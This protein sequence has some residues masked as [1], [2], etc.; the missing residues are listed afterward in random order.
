MSPIKFNSQGKSAH[1]LVA[2]V[3]RT[4]AEV[5][6]QHVEKKRR[7]RAIRQR[8]IPT[9]EMLEPHVLL[10]TVTWTNSS[11]GNW[12]VGTNWS[13]GS[14]P[15]SG[16]TAV[17]TGLSSGAQVTYSSGSSTV[18]AIQASSPLDITGGTLAVSGSTEI[19][20]TTVTVD[21]G[22]LEYGSS[23]TNSESGSAGVD[24]ASGNLTLDASITLSNLDFSGGT[25]N[26]T[27]SLSLDG[28]DTWSGGT[29]D[30]PVTVG[31]GATLDVTGGQLGDST[32]SGITLENENEVDIE[33]GSLVLNNSATIDNVLSGE[34]DLAAGANLDA[35]DSTAVSI[36]NDGYI[37]QDGGASPSAIEMPLNNESAGQVDVGG[38]ILQLD[39]GGSNTNIH[40]P[41]FADFA[42]NLEFNGGTFTFYG[43]ATLYATSD[44]QIDL[45][46]GTLSTNAT[47]TAY[48]FNMTGGTVDGTGSLA[49]VG[50]G[51]WDHGVL[52]VPLTVNSGATFDI[53]NG[54]L[55]DSSTSGVTLSNS[56]TVD[57]TGS[58]A[59]FNS[60]AI[61]NASGGV[62]VLDTG[63]SVNAG[64]SSALAFNNAGSLEE[65]GAASAA[66]DLPLV[67]ESTGTVVADG[68]TLQLIDGGS[69]ANTGTAFS[70]EDDGLLWFDVGTY[71]FSG[72]AT[73]TADS[74]SEI[75][76]D[77]VTVTADG[78]L[79]L[80]N[81]SATDVTVSGTGSLSF[82]GSDTWS[83]GSISVPPTVA[84]SGTVTF[85]SATLTLTGLTNQGTIDL[86]S[87]DT[88]SLAGDWTNAS[89]TISVPTGATL[90]LGGDFAT[91]DVGT[92]SN[93]GGE[94]QLTG[95]LDNTSATLNLTTST[96]GASLVME[97]GGSITGGTVD[98][99]SGSDLSVDASQTGTLDG[100]TV[101][102]TGN[103]DASQSGA[104]LT[105]SNGL[106]FSGT[107]T[108]GA[109]ATLELA[110]TETL[111]GGGTINAEQIGSIPYG[112]ENS[113]NIQIDDGATATLDTDMTVSGGS[114]F[115]PQNALSNFINEGQFIAGTG[116]DGEPQEFLWN[117]GGGTF[118]N[119]G[120]LDASGLGGFQT[121]S[122]PL[123]GAGYAISPTEVVFGWS[124]F[125]GS[126][127]DTFTISDSTNGVDFNTIST[128]RPSGNYLVAEGLMPNTSYSFR[129]QETSPGGASL[130]YTS[131]PIDTNISDPSPYA[132]LYIGTPPLGISDDKYGAYQFNN[133]LDGSG[134]P[135]SISSYK[136]GLLDAGSAQGAFLQSLDGYLS[137]NVQYDLLAL[138]YAYST[139]G[140]LS[141]GVHVVSPLCAP[142]IA[143]YDP[144]PVQATTGATSPSNNQCAPCD[145]D[146]ILVS[147]GATVITDTD[148]SSSGFTGAWS[149]TR[150]WT[151]QDTF[152]PDTTF[153]N[154]WMNQTQTYIQA[155]GNGSGNP[156]ILVVQN[157]YNQTLFGYN[158][159]T[160]TYAPVSY[161]NDAL[162]YDSSSDTYTWLNVATGGE[163]IYYGFS[164]GT[165]ANLQGKLKLYQD[166]YGNQ[167]SLTY[168][169]AG[170][171]TTV[172]QSDAAGDESIF[173]YDYLT[174]GVNAGKVSLIEEFVQRAGD[175]S[176]T[177]VEQ[178]AYAYYE[179]TYS[180]D[181]AFGNLGDLKT[182]TIEDPD[183][184]V[185]GEDYYRY[186]TPG[187]I[188]DGAEGFV[189]GLQYTFSTDSFTKLAAAFA[190][191][192][193]ATNAEIAP[194]A[195]EFY[196]YN[197]SRQVI[198]E[199]VGSM[200]ASD[201]LGQGTYH[202][203]Y[204]EN[205]SLSS[206]TED[207]NT[208][209]TRT[210]E[211]LPD[212]NQNIFYTSIDGD[213]ILEIENVSSD[214]GN[215]ANVGG[216]WI[217]GDQYDIFGRPLTSISTSAIN[218]GASILDGATTVSG[219]EA[220]LEPYADLG[221][222][223][224]L[225]YTSQGLITGTTY[226]SDTTATSTT[227]GDAA[228]FVETDFVQQGSSGS[229]INQHSY[230]YFA[231]ANA[232]GYTIYPVASHTQYESAASGGSNPQSTGYGYTWQS[233]SGSVT[234][235]VEDE[236]ITNPT[237]ST[238]D[239]GSG[240]ATSEQEVFNTFGQVVWT[241]DGNGYI[242]YA[243]YDNATGS[244]TQSVQ[245]VN[246]SD[247][248]DLRNYAGTTFTSGYNSLGVPQLP[249][250]WST[251]TGGGSTG[252]TPGG[253][254]LVTT[255]YVDNLG[256][257]IEQVSPAGNITLYAYDDID[258]A[259]FTLPGVVLNTEDDTL[260][261]TG[262]TTMT[263][264]DIPYSYTQGDSTLYGMYDET[265]TFSANTSISYSGGGTGEAVIPSM[266]GFIQGDDASS[267]PKNVLNLI[268]DGSSDSPQFTIQSLTRSLH[269]SSGRT[270]GQ[271]VETD[272]YSQI[273]NA[274]YLATDVWDPYSVSGTSYY[275]T[276]YGFD[277]DGR[278]YQTINANGTIDD[279]VFD[280]MD[281]PVSLWVGT[282]DAVSGASGTPSYF[283]GSN[284][285]SGNNMTDVESF[286]YD[287]GGIGDDDLTEEV[288]YPDG[289]TAGTQ[290]ASVLSYDFEDRLIAKESGLTLNDSGAAVTSGNDAYPQITVDTLDN[291][292][293]IEA[294]LTFNG[295]ATS[296]GDAIT[297]AG[298]TPPVETLTGLVGY[299]TNAYDS[300]KQNYQSQTFSVDPST[301]TISDTALT[302]Q[303]FYD[304]D[305]NVIETVAPNGQDTKNVFDG[306][307]RLTGTF[308]TDGGAVNNS[309]SP[310][311]TYAAASSVF[312]DVVIQQTAYGYNGDGDTIETVTAQRSSADPD[313]AEGA[314]FSDTSNSDGSLNV[315]AA[316]GDDS[317][318]GSMIDFDASYFD[319]ADRDIADVNVG[320]NGSSAWTRPT[321][322]PSD[323]ST[324]LVTGY[325]YDA[326][327]NQNTTTDPNGIETKSDFDALGRMTTNIA[328]YTDG[329]PTSSTNQTTAY[330]YDGLNDITSMTAVMPSGTPDQTTSYIYGV[331]TTGGSKIDSNDLLGL[332]DYPNP[333]TG[334]ASSSYQQ[335]FEYDAIGEEIS[336]TDQNGTNH[337]YGYDTAGR[338][339]SDSATVASGNP[340]NIDTSVA[341]LGYGYNSQGLPYQQTS[342][343]SSDDVVN[344]VEDVYNGLGQLANQYQSVS[345]AVNTST[346]PDV[347][348][349]YSD[350]TLGSRLTVM[351]YPNG[352]I[353]HYGYDGNALDD[354]IGRVDYLADDNGSGGIG[355]HDVNYSYLGL[356]TIVGQAQGN[357]ITETTTLNTFGEVGEIKYVNTSTSTTT[358][359]FQYGYDNDGN[360]LYEV[361]GVNANF[362]Q[363]FSY[364]DLNRLN[365]D[366][367]G[368]LNTGH[369]AITTDNTL[370]GSSQSW[371][372]DAV[373]NQTSVT[374]DGT[375][376]DNTVNSQNQLTVNGSSDLAYDKDGN[377]TTDENGDT[378]VYNAWNDLVAI[379]NSGGTI[380]TA[381]TY[382]A[383]GERTSQ[384]ASGTT[385]DFYL[386]AQ[387]QIIEERQGSVVTAQNVFNIDF[388]NDLLLRDDNSTSG[389]L[390]ISGSGLGE[391]LY[392]QHDLNF[393]VTALTNSGG[394]VAE[395]FI[396]T[397]Y[398][399]LTVLSSSWS[400]TSDAYNWSYYFQGMRLVPDG[401]GNLYLSQGRVYDSA[402]GN[403]LS[404]DSG[405]WDSANLYQALDSDPTSLVDPYGRSSVSIVKG[406]YRDA[407]H[408]LHAVYYYNRID[409]FLT[410]ETGESNIGKL[411]INVDQPHFK[412]S[413]MDRMASGLQ[414]TLNE[415][416]KAGNKV[417]GFKVV[418]GG[419]VVTAVVVT[420]G[421]ALSVAPGVVVGGGVIAGENPAIQQTVENAVQDIAT[422]APEIT[423][424]LENGGNTTTVIGRMQDL[425]QFAD[426]PSIDTWAK[427][428]R[429]PGGGEPPVTWAENQTWLDERICRGDDFG[430]ATDPTT[431]PP[432]KGGY[433]PGQPNGYFTAR[434]LEYLLQQGIDVQPMY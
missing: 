101:S 82:G 256:R 221:L 394:D 83:G 247:L 270:E 71:T 143:D 106:T 45:E 150:N 36:S 375:A 342:Y 302:A 244:V 237:V 416:I 192:F 430:I 78:T 198:E 38:G 289:N 423:Q 100:V 93:S 149:I 236:T 130:Q 140:Q 39:D 431:L 385:T 326:A 222:S 283:V 261:T 4:C 1:K 147:D 312:S 241:K 320:T 217:T 86:S 427:S 139:G 300:L 279:T 117:S 102:G 173:E 319:A 292:G 327:G 63:N 434:E 405:Y 189:G 370:P 9:V 335:A 145:G 210:T 260:T 35:G 152:V 43:H 124:G 318:L 31:S 120:R 351:I 48:D 206:A 180:G 407:N 144:G 376:K 330:A 123:L 76:L 360:V 148:L 401:Q 273:D 316:S 209:A 115:H 382:D 414:E 388:V 46:A 361:N 426:N 304:A 126:P 62:F 28:I 107:L 24:V 403:W 259:T 103:I 369:T 322:V 67:N 354:A 324:V 219:I 15:G 58:I 399:Q 274:S 228:G 262:P 368:T 287:N 90:A 19:D 97:D 81:V 196:E 404:Q 314:L 226:Y 359:D 422:D 398:G 194:Y 125:S 155:V 141:A 275:P 396:Y 338:E 400:T 160:D 413:K 53:S 380:L 308:I 68:Q 249:S 32:T 66:F 411:D 212:G 310:V 267:G 356:S 357:G 263:R 303:T 95:S 390:G 374:T 183:G 25:I 231:H 298:S 391:R 339:I 371:D 301:G 89:G 41:A 214:P 170:Q 417:T 94:V 268:G 200:G 290:D 158:S 109:A 3:R 33:S 163:S 72:N 397:P 84:A 346:T 349:D 47:L 341:E 366:Q 218:L 16:D 40:T 13:G 240:S 29:M 223:E 379:K 343:D 179:G 138:P 118:T 142:D 280:A 315:T 367:R 22:T 65:T 178:A 365:S 245:D 151:A 99:S 108:I 191:P 34:I 69:D 362:S 57:L 418:I 195:D 307:D 347:R 127:G 432:V 156:N 364:D 336:M 386:T 321:S 227:G 181:D 23:A 77:T 80:S 199:V 113:S 88:V 350:P 265:I 204:S 393:S 119:D 137:T 187:E 74:T 27:G 6:A 402:T 235:Q 288:Q 255:N 85:S 73:L 75:D 122:Q 10:S 185:L 59:L 234:N 317:S 253:L 250:G 169:D 61:D 17:I 387:G 114:I 293:N 258:H 381:Y 425:D 424:A 96:F 159:S 134:D 2:C 70:A 337:A 297:A 409:T 56:G 162:T 233:D 284:A 352:R 309:G 176:A 172:T 281:R 243:A 358:D 111:T 167:I 408:Q 51:A 54:T 20:S 348:Y 153:G 285:G 175:E 384:T 157:A 164:T 104:N 325:G 257:T 276:F 353:L 193:T 306:A 224:G 251:P 182:V 166:A 295:G 26:G 373:G 323:S 333:T 433:I 154:G 37:V 8:C 291:L 5:W 328:D 282:D 110:N 415:E 278:P 128:S 428:G 207:F 215:P 229:P 378:E 11:G 112:D 14:V 225:V 332:I 197:S 311:L 42:A 363:L 329:T 105:V 18:A 286:I 406:H 161:S 264:T 177:L 146:P 87:G 190:D 52:D 171:L 64:D 313:D 168:S 211:T 389:S 60:A 344:Q 208:W 12:N 165:A 246:T 135:I 238:E 186:Y 271:L 136:S 49:V 129:V 421:Y 55:G 7:Q 133:V 91:S 372:L 174:S 296:I 334:Y 412:E 355:S 201:S 44:S 230:T 50:T 266:P 419:L 216:N 377:T 184:N 21:G 294:T 79:S 269:N 331:T 242:S 299:S 92:L 277:A 202:F 203:S 239:N 429:I 30:V 132:S 121:S 410:Y 345:G 220:A 395:R 254:N 383:D 98:E 420:G 392:A 252:L 232:A 213:Q 340:Y 188:A 116:G 205:P 305:G 248:S 272:A 131:Y